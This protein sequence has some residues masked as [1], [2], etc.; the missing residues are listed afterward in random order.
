MLHYSLSL[1]HTRQE[2]FK[3]QLGRAKTDIKKSF[4]TEK[5]D[6]FLFSVVFYNIMDWNVWVFSR[7]N[8][9]NL[10][11]LSLEIMLSRT[12][13]LFSVLSFWK[14]NIFV[15]SR[16]KCSTLL[17]LHF[18]HLEVQQKDYVI[19]LA[20]SAGVLKCHFNVTLLLQRSLCLIHIQFVKHVHSW[21]FSLVCELF[22]SLNYSCVILEPPSWFSVLNFT[23]LLSDFISQLV[24]NIFSSI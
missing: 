3:L 20:G 4:L 5:P 23:L 11:C 16:T 13:L 7:L 24:A 17:Q 1:W 12:Q 15:V 6:S 18:Y 2:V 21:S 22:M 14:F 8:I 9:P 10:L 19:K